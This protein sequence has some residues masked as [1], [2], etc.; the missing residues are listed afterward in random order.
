MRRMRAGGHEPASL[1]RGAWF[2]PAFV[3]A[4]LLLGLGSAPGP[5]GRRPGITATDGRLSITLSIT[6]VRAV[7]GAAVEFNL[8][9]AARAAKGALG[10]VVRFGDGS[11][12]TIPIPM[13][14][15]AGPGRPEHQAWRLSHR[16]TRAGTYDVSATGFANC[17]SG[18]ATVTASVVIT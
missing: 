15:L 7:P 14:C 9:V 10:Y 13:Y 11:I 5:I 3:A 18:R 4:G 17:G 6:P 12:S 1:G 16:Y 2:A 8:S